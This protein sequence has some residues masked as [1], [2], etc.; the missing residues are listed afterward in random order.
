MDENGVWDT[1]HAERFRL[2]EVLAGVEDERWQE[3]TWCSEWT[4]SQAVAHLS[5]AADTRTVAWIRSI[6]LAGFRSAVHNARLVKKYLGET[7]AETLNTFRAVAGQRVSPTNHHAAMLGEIIVHGQDITRPLDLDLVPDPAGVQEVARFFASRDFT[8]GSKSLT[9]GLSLRADDD[10]FAV[11]D[12]PLVRGAQLDLVM[13]MAGR[14][15]A[16]ERLEGDGVP[17]LR[18]RLGTGTD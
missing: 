18:R 1:I 3:M 17:V 10:S 13:A 4:V 16:L 15:Q 9:K 12:G 2:I 7:P 5:A 8:V 11:G 14:A 6:V